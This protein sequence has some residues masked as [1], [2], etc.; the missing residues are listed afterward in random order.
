MKKQNIEEIFSSIEHFSSVPPPELWG[1]IEEKLNQPKKSKKAIIWWTA[2]ACLLAGLMVPT[3]LHFNSGADINTLNTN[4]TNTVVLEEKN[5][6]AVKNNSTN[7]NTGTESNAVQ[8]NTNKQIVNSE[9]DKTKNIDKEA[10]DK[11]VIDKKVIEVQNTETATATLENSPEKNNTTKVQNTTIISN[12]ATRTAHSETKKATNRAVFLDIKQTETH[13][14]NQAVAVKANTSKK[15]NNF[16]DVSKQQMTTVEKNNLNQA[17]AE[18]NFTSKATDKVATSSKNSISKKE[19]ELLDKAV[20]ENTFKTKKQ[21]S[22]NASPEKSISGSV[23]GEKLNA[24]NNTTFALNNSNSV[25]KENENQNKQ[26]QKEINPNFNTIALEKSIADN[27]SVNNN[28]KNTSKFGDALSKQD[29]V[30]LAELQNLEKGIIVAE[31]TKEEKEKEDKAVPKSEKWDLGVFAGVANSEN[32]KNEKTLGNVNDSKQSNSYGVKTRYKINKKWAVGSGL[33]FN[34]LGQSIANVA[35]MSTKS[36]ATFTQSDYLN[37]SASAVKPHIANNSN[38]V[39]LSNNTK[40]SFKSN[41][42]QTGNVNQSLKYIEMPLEV[43][44]AVLTLNKASVSLNTGGFVGKL[45][46]NNVSLNGTSIGE[47][48][49][50]ND[51]VYGSVLSS[52][53]QYRVYKKTNVFVEPAMNYYVNPLNNQ[54]FNQ[55][56]W[57]LN[58]GLNVS[59]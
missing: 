47:N 33:K 26:D 54:S 39:F 25:L 13:S 21:K 12:T 56:Q 35:Y 5:S 46:S 7:K 9:N 52:T 36:E 32:Y 24:K 45:V 30:Q 15:E 11:K 17:V 27:N 16:N 49:D 41:N 59:F 1:Q 29:S 18:Q 53:V 19:K 50:A 31:V 34:E 38:Y 23:V 42:I 6:G 57:G 55:F 20:A 22:F 14:P 40:N 58:F 3:V 43:S 51:F 2:A 28:S 10:I 8:E 44:Y 37:Q 4:S 48:I